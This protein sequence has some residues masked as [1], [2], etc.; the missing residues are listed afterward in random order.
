MG[1][2]DDFKKQANEVRATVSKQKPSQPAQTNWYKGSQPTQ[3]E[4]LARIYEIG[5]QDETKRVDL[6]R[7]YE[8][9]VQN[10]SSPIYNPYAS[11]T[12]S[13][14]TQTNINNTL[15]AQDEWARLSDELSYWATRTDRNYS[16]DEIISRINWDNYKTLQKMD[17]G[18]QTGNPLALLD[19]VGYSEDAMYGVLWAARNPGAS[20]GNAMYDAAQRELGRGNQYK[21]S[22]VSAYRDATSAYYSPYK[23][24]ATA[25]D[26]LAYKYGMNGD[27]DEAWLNGAGRS[28]L[29]GG[30]ESRK[31]YARIYDTVMATNEYRADIAALNKSITDKIEAG[32]SPDEIFNDSMFDA[33]PKAKE[34]YESQRRGILKDTSGAV[35]FSLME[36]YETAEKA[37]TDRMGRVTPEEYNAEVVNTLGS[38][39]VTSNSAKVVKPQTAEQLRASRSIFAPYATEME[40][41]VLQ[42]IDPTYG[43]VKANVKNGVLNGSAGSSEAYKAAMTDADD[44]A[45]QNYLTNLDA[46]RALQAEKEALQQYQSFYDKWLPKLD[47]DPV[48]TMSDPEYVAESKAIQDAMA[49]W[50]KYAG[51]AAA[52]DA[53]I[54]EQQKLQQKILSKYADAELLNESGY[55]GSTILPMLN[56]IDQFNGFEAGSYSTPAY[57]WETQLDSGTDWSKVKAGMSQ[58]MTTNAQYLIQLGTAIQQAELYGVPENYIEGMQNAK[59]MLIAENTAIQYGLVRDNADFSAKVK[60]FDETQEPFRRGLRNLFESPTRE[61]IIKTTIIDPVQAVKAFG[62]D[63]ADVL[64]GQMSESEKE[65]YK[66]LY[67]TEGE[68]RATAY[69]ESLVPQLNARGYESMMEQAQVDGLGEA[70]GKTLASIFINAGSV[71]PLMSNAI[72]SMNGEKL[73]P[74]SP[75]NWLTAYSGEVRASSKKAISDA[76]KDN[77]ILDKVANFAYDVATTTADSTTAGLIGGGQLGALF[78]MG[79]NAAQ[80]TLMDASSRNAE[81]WQAWA[82]AGASAAAE[83]LTEFLP[84]GNLFEAFELGGTAAIK[85][86]GENIIKGIASDAPGEMVS[87]FLNGVTDDLI[88]QE[89]SNSNLRIQ[90]L[91]DE[92]KIGYEEAS[93]IVQHEAMTNILYSGL[94]SVGTTV[95]TSTSAFAGGKI[96]GGLKTKRNPAITRAAGVLSKAGNGGS[97]EKA[98]TISGVLE[99]MGA[100]PDTADAVAQTAVS[101]NADA[102]DAVRG[103]LLHTEDEAVLDA[104]E[105]GTMVPE[106]Q[107]GQVLAE[108][109]QNGATD[110]N[111]AALVEAA[112]QDREDPAVLDQLDGAVLEHAEGAASVNAM[113]GNTAAYE[114]VE[115]TE[116]EA[117]KNLDAAQG[118]YDKAKAYEAKASA[119]LGVASHQFNNNP[120]DDT[121]KAAMLSGIE[122][123]NAAQESSVN[124]EQALNDAKA[125]YDEAHAEAERQRQN[126]VA[127]ARS[128]AEQYVGQR[129]QE[130]QAVRVGQEA[131]AEV[132]Q[133]SDNISALEANDFIEDTIPDVNDDEFGS[134]QQIYI[135]TVGEENAA[136]PDEQ[137]SAS[138]DRKAVEFVTK[139]SK[140]FKVKFD[141]V[142]SD[143]DF[144]GKYSNGVV[145]INKKATQGEAIRKVAL[146]ELIHHVEKTGEYKTLV[147]LVKDYFFKGDMEA[148]DKE[149][150]DLRQL[151]DS[152]KDSLGIKEEIDY[153]YGERELVAEYAARIFEADEQFIERI[154][155]EKPS[156]A[157][158]IAEALKGIVDKLRGVND[159]ELDMIRKA[160]KAFR[161]A[162][163]KSADPR[164]RSLQQVAVTSEHPNAEQFSISQFAR[165]AGLQMR[166]NSDGAPYAIVDADGNEVKNVTPD[167]IKASPMGKLITTAQNNGAIDADTAQKQYD[168]FAELMTMVAE[169]KDPAM[170]WESAGSELFSAIKSN[171]DA[172]YSTTVDFGTICSKTRE[173]VNVMSETMLK[174]GRGLTREEVIDAYNNTHKAG[175][176]VPCPVCYVFSRWMGVPS[177][178][179][180]MRKGQE[181]FANATDADVNAYLKSV[182]E[183]YGIEGK[184]LSESVGKAKTKVQNKLK[185]ISESL[186]K[187]VFKNNADKTALIEQAKALEAELDEIEMFNWV[188][189]VLC[190]TDRKRKPILDKDGN[191]TIDPSYKAV[192][193]EVLLDLRRTG[194]FASDYAKAWTFRTTRGAGMGKAILPYSGA[195]LGDT[196]SGTKRW[197]ASQN[198]YFTGDDK[199]AARKMKFAQIRAKA[200]NLIGGQRFQS[201]SD[202]R[203]EWGLDY[204]STFLE[205]QAI[206]AKGQLYTKVI[207]AVDMFATAGIE[208]NMSIMPKNNGYHLD[209]NGNPVLGEED[210]SD[211]TGIGFKGALEKTQ[212]YDNAQMILVGIN[213]THIE[214]AM[215]DDRISFI[216]PWHSSGNSKDTLTTLMN[217]VGE[218]LTNAEDYTDIQTD[219]PSENQTPEQKAMWDLRME[220]LT[221]KL[222]RGVSDEQQKLLDSNPYLKAMYEK[223]YVD[224]SATDTYGVKLSKAQAG[225]IFPHEYWDTNLTVDQADENGRRFVE[226]CATMGIEPRFGKFSDKPGYWKLLIDR[227]MYNRD[228]TYHVPQTI[229]VTKVDIADVASEVSQA[230]VGTPDQISKAVQGTIDDINARLP[231][232]PF[233]MQADVDIDADNSEGQYS[234]PSS[235]VLKRQVRSWKSGQ[236]TADGTPVEYSYAHVTSLKPM[237]VTKVAVA[238]TYMNGK[239]PDRAKVKADCM[240]GVEAQGNPRNSEKK[241][242]VEN[243]YTKRDIQIT[244][245]ALNHAL[246]G[247]KERVDRNTRVMAVLGSVLKHA[248]PVNNFKPRDNAVGTELLLGIAEDENSYY[249]VA[250]VVNETSEDMGEL[251]GIDFLNGINKQYVYSA[252]ADNYNKKTGGSKPGGF[253]TNPITPTSSE[254]SIAEVLDIVKNSS[255]QDMLSGFS[256]DILNGMGFQ[257][258]PS[259]AFNGSAVYSVDSS[260]V[261]PRQARRLGQPQGNQLSRDTEEPNYG[262][263]ERQFAGQTL[264]NSTVVPDWIKQEFLRPEELNY[265]EDTNREQVERGWQRIQ[266]NGFEAE[267]D[268]LL[269]LD[270]YS[271]DDTAEAN[272]MMAMALREDTADP[273]T[274]MALA[275]HYNK[276]GTKAGQELQARKLFTRMSPTGARVWAAGQMENRLEEHM[277]THRPQRRQVDERAQQVAGEIRGLQGGDEV[278]RLNAGGDFTIDESNNRWGIPINQQQQALIDH[279]NLNNV[280]R[281]GIF[282]N[283]ATTQQRMLEAIIATPNPLE[284]TGL[285]LNLIQRLEYMAAGEAVITNAD[286]NY[287]GTQLGQFVALG[288]DEGGRDADLAVSRAYEAYGNITPST[289][290]EKMRTWRYVSMLLS[291]PSATRNVIGNAAQNAVNATAH[292]IAVELDK[293]A[294]RV[295]GQRTVEHLSVQERIDGWRGFVD[296]T[297]NTFRDYFVDRSITQRGNDKYNTNQRGR[298]YQNQFIETMRNVEGFLMSF[299]DRNMWR[300]AYLNS[301]AEQQKL[302]DRGLLFNDDGTTRTHEQ[303]LDQAEAD[304]NYATFTEDN[305]VSNTLSQMKNIPGVGEVIDFIMPFTGVPTNITRRMIQYSPL[306]LAGAAIQHGYRFATRQN[307]DQR[308]FVDSVSRGLTGT[309][310]LGVGII[311]AMA[312]VIKPGTGDEDDDKKYGLKTAMGGQYTPYVYNPLNDEYVSLAAFAPAVS[313]LT[314][315][316]A[317]YEEFKNNDDALQALVSTCFSGLD[318]I[319]DASYMS[320]I[321]DIFKGYGSPAE[322]IVNAV[323]SNAVSQNVPALLTQLSNTIDPYVRDTKDKNA[324]MQALKSGLIN[325]IP[326]VR[327]ALLPEKVDVMGQPVRTKEGLRNFYDP[328]TTTDARKDPAVDE[329]FRLSESLGSS[330]M[331]PSDALSGSKT[332]LTVNKQKVTLDGKGKE[333]YR[334]RYGELWLEG[335]ETIDKKGRPVVVEGVRKLMESS[336]YQLM[337]DNERADAIADILSEAKTGAAMEALNK[338]GAD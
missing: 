151:Y 61:E 98:A 281:P 258:R 19:A 192:P 140:L 266:Q 35:D 290:R 311:A 40:K 105:I 14:Q 76:F 13:K 313:P 244:P 206:G 12:T 278:L 193:N 330:S 329:L 255:S 242:F 306:G 221:G 209:E 49:V 51:D 326:G 23:A 172:Q 28:L 286:L 133:Q 247:S 104:I 119:D 150:D 176:A 160:E 142:E 139:L 265:E 279:Y 120:A 288:A 131:A 121:F 65:T 18:R 15:K 89:M 253:E 24:G 302:A 308:A 262:S 212:K 222:K 217:A 202:Y 198:P 144:E 97:A 138:V 7:M 295:T 30:E 79:T 155:A 239:S 317:A 163:E 6:M 132:Q 183:K 71:F 259:G 141:F 178:L 229:D 296:E 333:A 143:N 236:K 194:E 208:V 303:M 233:D 197:A 327:E 256:M 338:Y 137:P 84:T 274:F 305:A 129:A 55:A 122:T 276:E 174:K 246:N 287:I 190:K 146:H 185:K 319:F 204:L 38:T 248:L 67:M 72:A 114:A 10:P 158:R 243:D 80:S 164:A 316:L 181:R 214:L 134:I 232:E 335:G 300:K 102:A 16:D 293:L 124:A 149:V 275:S 83:T 314:M 108:I 219:K 81:G 90:Q 226:Y 127:A 147:N 238:G 182:S 107:T 161:K 307:F 106:S 301:L 220:I 31:D 75:S 135:S 196:I 250:I 162:L 93:A 315:G 199:V 304:A 157:V 117:K 82:L 2:F 154:V 166:T 45:A 252:N 113:M 34:L 324:I 111:A 32:M 298:V 175:M 200:Q 11:A 331:L 69:Y 17:E 213:D 207:E 70:A 225:Q 130:I 257:T 312:G 48:N 285:G 318:Q 184:D 234:V 54:A 284:V 92:Y 126:L 168:M 230:K 123:L 85:E 334:K 241:K 21:A 231:A 180:T 273:A 29:N 294:S 320:G 309:A 299:G 291:V 269:S 191:V 103:I 267:R 60:E 228:G 156:L 325:R 91:M 292:G 125:A 169:Y 237:P 56:F 3:R 240:A 289:A 68:E 58:Q 188:N 87:E 337:D 272:L 73:D 96:M 78:L 171:S 218:S 211:V 177:L 170:I 235:D 39:D 282:Y 297:R 148:Y 268:R 59:D 203:P 323:F 179:E 215:A 224:E 118:E 336:A 53:A 8:E 153:A 254:L 66:Y 165:A 322:N 283:R 22:G 277:S 42:N 173:V 64:A 5:K 1:V 9:E 145:T 251:T 94:L 280:A 74:Y 136:A 223:F 63:G 201:T 57:D 50:D 52:I 264:Q 186:L 328:F 41:R 46:L 187:D 116:A 37:Y 26:D 195:E 77:P 271:A 205:M 36:M 33:F 99:G 128:Q 95:G 88:M 249:P 261:L 25:L 109:Q 86:L 47:A 263:G 310:L 189:Q 4:T 115:K 210:F 20:T 216:I 100:D 270:R 245:N 332:T 260:S 159:P 110:E 227:R 43:E 44:F 101:E 167:M 152:R 112:K 27:F 62:D 321:Q